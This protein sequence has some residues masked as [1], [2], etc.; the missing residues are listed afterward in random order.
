M[1]TKNELNKGQ[2]REITYIL[3]IIRFGIKMSN[4]CS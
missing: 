4:Y 2:I 3:N 1:S